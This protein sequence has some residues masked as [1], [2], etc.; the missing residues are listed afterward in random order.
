[1]TKEL[2][3]YMNTKNVQTEHFSTLIMRAYK[4]AKEVILGTAFH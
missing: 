1:M 4:S 2:P 3:K